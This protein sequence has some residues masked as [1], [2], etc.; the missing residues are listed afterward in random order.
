MHGHRS[1]AVP[2]PQQLQ[3]LKHNGIVPDMATGRGTSVFPF[4]LTPGKGTIEVGADSDQAAEA[5]LEHDVHWTAAA[6][7][8][9]GLLEPQHPDPGIARKG[10]T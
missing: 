10:G 7:S 1:G 4:G 2:L 5:V 9:A 6:Q 8:L 3:L